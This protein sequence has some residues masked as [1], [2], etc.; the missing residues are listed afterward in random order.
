MIDLLRSWLIGITAA[1]MIAALIDWIVPDGITKKISKL[2]GGLL[3]LV[4][5]LQPLVAVGHTDISDEFDGYRVNTEGYSKA[6]EN[7]NVRLMKI[8][9]E[10]ETAAYIQ[11]KA[12]ELGLVCDV[13]VECRINE[14][15]KP[16]PAAIEVAGN[17]TNAQIEKLTQLIEADLAIPKDRQ[18]YER[19]LMNE[20]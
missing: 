3:I 1:A 14:E 11:D 5:I 9:I 2:A 7:E 19:K 13:S 18:C 10:E 20:G 12:K 17:F 15:N 4:A 16:Y 8:I 6:L